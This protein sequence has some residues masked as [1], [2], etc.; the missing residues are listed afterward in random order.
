MK[1]LRVK[2]KVKY[3]GNGCGSSVCLSQKPVH[4]WQLPTKTISEREKVKVN[5]KSA[6]WRLPCLPNPPITNC[7]STHQKK[8]LPW[9]QLCSTVYCLLSYSVVNFNSS[10]RY[11]TLISFFCVILYLYLPILIRHPYKMMPRQCCG[12]HKRCND[13]ATR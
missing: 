4:Q 5:D 2:V 8:I 11:P 1:S 3:K 12:R 7:T 9:F 10:T 13:Y 6:W